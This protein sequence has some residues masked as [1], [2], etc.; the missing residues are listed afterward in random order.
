MNVYQKNFEILCSSDGCPEGWKLLGFD[1]AITNENKIY[2]TGF[3]DQAIFDF[4]ER[5]KKEKASH[6]AEIIMKLK[7]IDLKSIRSIRDND[8]EYIEKYRKEAEALR[9]Q[10]K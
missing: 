3:T 7:E 1:K 2:V 6:N 9:S 10:L 5:D 4:T 8:T